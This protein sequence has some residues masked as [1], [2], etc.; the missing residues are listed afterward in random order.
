MAEGKLHSLADHFQTLD[1]MIDEIQEAKA[2]FIGL[3]DRLLQKRRRANQDEIN[4]YSWLTIA[5]EA[6]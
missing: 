6:A 1:W 5:A 2:T 4:D 3:R